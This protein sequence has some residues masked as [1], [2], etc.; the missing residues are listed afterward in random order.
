MLSVS[1]SEKTLMTTIVG[2]VA[3]NGKGIHESW[4]W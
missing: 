3:A 2:S 4:D 1:D